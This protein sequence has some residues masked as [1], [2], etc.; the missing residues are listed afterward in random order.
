M[1][2]LQATSENIFDIILGY[3]PRLIG[4]IITLIIGMW[5]IS[6]IRGGTL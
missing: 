6:I 5:I 2:T 1:E 4:A 3:S